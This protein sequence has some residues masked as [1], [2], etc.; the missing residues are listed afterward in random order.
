M[1]TESSTENTLL[2]KITRL[3]TLMVKVTQRLSSAEEAIKE[4]RDKFKTI[5]TSIGEWLDSSSTRLENLEA[6]VADW[7]TDFEEEENVDS[8]E[9][10]TNV[11]D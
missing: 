4:Q 1:S 2:A 11:Q 10:T 5:I 8:T 3:E 6:I 7:E 9:I